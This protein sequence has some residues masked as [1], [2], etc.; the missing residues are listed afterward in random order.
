M[1]SSIRHEETCSPLVR[2]GRH[3]PQVS[4]MKETEPTVLTGEAEARLKGGDWGFFQINRGDIAPTFSPKCGCQYPG[5]P[6]LILI[7]IRHSFHF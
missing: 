4:L 1:W 6:S 2:W 5:G 3:S 7:S